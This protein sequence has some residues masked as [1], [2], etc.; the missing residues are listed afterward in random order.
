M[1]APTKH[2]MNLMETGHRVPALEAENE[3]LKVQRDA[4]LEALESI[5]A[6]GLATQ[7]GSPEY[8]CG[9]IAALAQK[10]IDKVRGGEE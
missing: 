5:K 7:D 10:A 4:L 9:Y 1:S 8:R 6:K 3:Q 2:Q